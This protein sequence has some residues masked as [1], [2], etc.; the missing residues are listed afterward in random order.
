MSREVSVVAEDSF[1][2]LCL[3]NEAIFGGEIFLEKRIRCFV[4][5]A[6]GA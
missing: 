2:A 5:G 3:T 6:E 4:T 1:Q